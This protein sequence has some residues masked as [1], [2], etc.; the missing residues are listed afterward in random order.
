MAFP[1]DKSYKTRPVPLELTHKGIAYKGIAVPAAQTCHDGVC[2]ELDITLNSE[3]LGLIHYKN[4]G[5][6]MDWV[7]DQGLVDAIGQE[8]FLWYE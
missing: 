1:A 7:R 8:I 6:K 4:N 2:F 3:H 5:W